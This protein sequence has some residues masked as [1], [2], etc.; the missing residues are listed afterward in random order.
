MYK[1]FTGTVLLFLTIAI[2]VLFTVGLLLS[3]VHYNLVT[4]RIVIAHVSIGIICG[5][6]FL[7]KQLNKLEPTSGGHFVG[8]FLSVIGLLVVSIWALGHKWNG[9]LICSGAGVS[10][11]LCVFVKA[12]RWVH[13]SWM[14]VSA[15]IAL[16]WIGQILFSVWIFRANHQKVMQMQ[17]PNFSQNSG[18][19][20]ETQGNVAPYVVFRRY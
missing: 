14:A 19:M 12:M 1:T 10:E 18:V 20:Y 6:H 9:D 17:T 15:G 4:A 3:G 5:V 11:T 16:V 13:F 2:D 8:Q 7:Y